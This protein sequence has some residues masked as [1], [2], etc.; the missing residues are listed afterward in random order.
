MNKEHPFLASQVSPGLDYS[1]LELRVF[2]EI[3]GTKKEEIRNLVT[4]GGQRKL[5]L[6]FLKT[7]PGITRI[8][9]IRKAKTRAMVEAVVSG[10]AEYGNHFVTCYSGDFHF[11]YR[12]TLIYKWNGVRDEGQEVNAGTYEATA[13]TM[14]QRKEI[15]KA[16]EN[17]KATVFAL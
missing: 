16:I 12:G 7:F 17:F 11:F 3:Y 14:N 15:Q 10:S 2:S 9:G 8:N 5:T 6:D 13:S 1:G 4:E